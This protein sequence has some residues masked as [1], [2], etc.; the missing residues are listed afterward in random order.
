M[1]PGRYAF[2]ELIERQA[3]RTPASDALVWDGGSLTYASLNQQANRLAHRLVSDLPL[4]PEQVVAVAL[5][6]SP[7]LV[8]A[9]LAV[10]KSGAAYLPLDPNYPAPRLNLVLESAGRPPIVTTRA[11]A[12]RAQFSGS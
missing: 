4:Q 3:A 2:Y 1:V 12:A 9:L 7:L 10:V 11:I 5:P 8:T 6:R